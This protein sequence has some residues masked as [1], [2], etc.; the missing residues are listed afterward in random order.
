[1]G[2]TEINRGEVEAE[3]RDDRADVCSG[4]ETWA[5]IIV[6]RIGRARAVIALITASGLYRPSMQIA[7]NYI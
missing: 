2:E 1:M 6:P 5:T 7:A 3:F 4:S